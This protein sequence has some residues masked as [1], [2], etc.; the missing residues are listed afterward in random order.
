V[1]DEQP[2][3]FDYADTDAADGSFLVSSSNAQAVSL[4]ERWRSWPGGSLALFGPPGSGKSH[5]LRTWAEEARAGFLDPRAG[6][7]TV[8]ALFTA[9][10]GRIAVDNM[11]GPRDDAAAMALLDLARQQ[12][13]AV[14]ITG[15]APPIDWSAGLPDL[16]SRFAALVAARLEDPD[17]QLLQDVIRRLCRRR[18][19]EL[20]ENVA[21]YIAENGERSFAAAQDLVD[22]LD[23]MLTAGRRPVA[24]DLAAEALRRV[25]RRREAEDTP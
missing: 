9:H 23:R 15:T 11:D 16:R 21:K 2:R 5:L 19:I 20:R 4:V 8:E 24:Y 12:G 7:A 10:D 14:L 17:L 25:A 13:G 1:T 18:F 3:L 22:E 6:A